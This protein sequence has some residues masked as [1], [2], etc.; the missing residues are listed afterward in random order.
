M[1]Q[2]I[3]TDL[4]N[5]RKSRT[6]PEHAEGRAYNKHI[7]NQ[8]RDR[9]CNC[10]Q[11]LAIS[12][13]QLGLTCNLRWSQGFPTLAPSGLS[14]FVEAEELLWSNDLILAFIANDM[15]TTIVTGLAG[16]LVG[17]SSSFEQ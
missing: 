8:I 11:L 14:H 12:W 13:F 3:Q 1:I 15:L 10:F 16:F 7:N 5:H 2:N 17:S 9:Y 6:R 4:P